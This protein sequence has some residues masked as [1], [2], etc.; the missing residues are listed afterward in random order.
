MRESKWNMIDIAVTQGSS[1]GRKAPRW[2][3]LRAACNFLGFGL[4]VTM[5]GGMDS[6]RPNTRAKDAQAWSQKV[7]IIAA[8]LEK[9][10]PKVIFFPHQLDWNDTHIGV[11]LLVMDALKAAPVAECDVVETEF[12]GQMQSPNLMV[13]Y[14]AADVA[15]LVA[16]TSFH[17]GEVKRNPY[18]LLMPA[19]MQDNVRRGA[20]LVGG[21]GGA[22]AAIHVRP[23]LPRPKWDGAGAAILRGRAFPFQVRQRR[24]SFFL[25]LLRPPKLFFQF[26]KIHFN[27]RRTPVRTRVQASRNAANPPPDSAIPALRASRSL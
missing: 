5:P 4:E 3:E 12:W 20:E 23:G 8:L 15:D 2:E 26:P 24:N 7:G 19:W 6:V 10:R 9:H 25:S 13:E 21:Q 17:V 11:H 18:H 14:S 27:Q 16:A 22:G 1:P